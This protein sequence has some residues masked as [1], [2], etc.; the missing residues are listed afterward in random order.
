MYFSCP[1]CL[2]KI[3]IVMV[4]PTLHYNI[5]I[6]AWSGDEDK[7]YHFMIPQRLALRS[8]MNSTRRSMK[9]TMVI[10]FAEKIGLILLGNKPAWEA[11]ECTHSQ[12][13]PKK[14]RWHLGEL[15]STNQFYLLYVFLKSWKKTVP[16]CCISR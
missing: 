16:T 8:L 9:H 1:M 12:I 13:R 4:M 5:R 14:E 6:L 15:S 2:R 7:W 3:K 10:S 11:T